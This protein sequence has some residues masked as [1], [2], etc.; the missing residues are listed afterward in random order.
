[1][2]LN[3]YQK[4]EI[5]VLTLFPHFF[6]S[7]TS[8]MLQ[9]L[10]TGLSLSVIHQKKYADFFPVPLNFLLLHVEICRRN[11]EEKNQNH[12]HFGRQ[13]EC[14]KRLGDEIKASN[15]VALTGLALCTSSSGSMEQKEKK[16]YFF[17][18]W[19]RFLIF[20]SLD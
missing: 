10:Q 4:K 20:S 9:M 1:M 14:L 8:I 11:D 2:L 16:Q 6:M 17:H 13:F 18:S 19:R 7:H 5:E 3:S 12:Y 15:A